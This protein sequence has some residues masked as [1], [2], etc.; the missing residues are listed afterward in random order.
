MGKLKRTLILFVE[1]IYLIQRRHHFRPWV[2]KFKPLL[3]INGLEQ[4]KSMLILIM[5]TT[6]EMQPKLSQSYLE[7]L[8]PSKER[9]ITSNSIFSTS[10]LCSWDISQERTAMILGRSAI[11]HV[12]VRKYWR[13]LTMITRQTALLF[14]F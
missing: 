8:L 13:W 5:L 3:S 10:F 6:L 7:P 12:F 4:G 14:K 11:E 9:R 1:D 2:A